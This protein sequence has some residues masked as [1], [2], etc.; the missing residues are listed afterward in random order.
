MAS[1]W[2]SY[3]DLAWTEDLL[4]DPADYKVE[5]DTYL[6]IIKRAAQR[7]L[8]TMLHL[9]SGAGGH[10]EYFKRHFFVTGVDLSKGMLDKAR[11]AHPDIEYHEGDMRTIRLE[12]RFDVV[13]IPDSIDYMASREDLRRAM[14]TCVTHLKPGGVLLITA[15]TRETFQNNNF[16]YEGHKDHVRV[17]LFENNYVNP[18]RPDTYEA[19]FVYMVRHKG[20]LKIHTENQVL[21]LYS[22]DIWEKLFD[23]FALDM[24][25]SML[26]GTYDNYILGDGAYPLTVFVGSKVN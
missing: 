18:F 9:G 7:P 6:D 4:A 25:K 11:Q 26:N 17:T 14:Q 21:G 2:K 16:V 15:K 5:V 23:E 22:L 19:T 8:Q 3:N 1:T 10:D 24:E 13:A 20:E 12:R